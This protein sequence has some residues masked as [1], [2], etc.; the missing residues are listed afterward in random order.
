[1]KR[2]YEIKAQG[3]KAEI[4][5]YG[6]I[7]KGFLDEEGIVA[8]DFVDELNA[9]KDVSEITV[10]LNSPGGYVDADKAI[11][12]SLVKHPAKINVEI[13]GAAYSIASLVAMA[14]DTISIAENAM[15]MIHDPM[16]C[17]CGNS[18]E[19]RKTADMMDKAKLTM[20]SSYKRHSKLSDDEISAAM[21]E[22]TWYTA[23]EAVEAG[24]ATEITQEIKMAA[25]HGIDKFNY[26][27]M[28][29][30]LKVEDEQVLKPVET[31]ANAEN[32]DTD[33]WKHTARE[34]ELA[35]MEIE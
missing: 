8:K 32:D 16:S 4:M 7:G 23:Q 12:N 10:R 9:L 24:F 31:E 33:E 11:Y 1:M 3:D 6:I 28:P 14:G 22:E 26:R 29:K 19:L 17:I 5:I 21:T 34:R 27:H 13:E 35:L 2:G 25:L 20:I 30:N 18:G 15:V